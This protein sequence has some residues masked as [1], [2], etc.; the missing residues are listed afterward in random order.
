[1]SNRILTPVAT[2]LVKAKAAICDTDHWCQDEFCSLDSKTDRMSYCALGALGYKDDD[3]F[4]NIDSRSHAK[5]LLEQVAKSMFGLSIVEVNDQLGFTEVHICYD[6]A[7]DR[8]IR[9]QK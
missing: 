1:M 4:T 3:D 8:A 2:V 5:T 6:H 7:I 9:E